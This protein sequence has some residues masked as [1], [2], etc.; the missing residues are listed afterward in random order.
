MDEYNV[1]SLFSSDICTD[2]S[3]SDQSA[4]IKNLQRKVS[5]MHAQHVLA[6]LLR[7]VVF[8]GLLILGL[9]VVESSWGNPLAITAGFLLLHTLVFSIQGHWNISCFRKANMYWLQKDTVEQ[10]VS[11]VFLQTETSVSELKT[12]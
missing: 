3:E 2:A 9:N 12:G 1:V 4:T 8:G 11:P 7:A 5:R 10:D 6:S